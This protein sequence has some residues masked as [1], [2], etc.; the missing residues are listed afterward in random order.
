MLQGTFD[1][2]SFK[3][4]LHLLAS[5]RKTGALRM[6]AGVPST[7]W[8]EDGLCCAAEGGDLI[9]PVT[10]EGEMLARLV[11]IGFA[12]ARNTGGTFRFVAEER[13]TWQSDVRISIDRVLVEVDGLLARWREIESVVPSLECRPTLCDQLGTERLTVDAGR[14]QL[15]VL[16][17]GRRSVRELSHRTGR[18]VFELCRSLIEL[19]DLGA[20]AIAPELELAVVPRPVTEGAVQPEEP[21]GPGV[22]TPHRGP[23]HPELDDLEPGERGALLR[24]FGALKEE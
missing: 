13:S 10:A 20:V 1:T 17:D 7:W 18:S 24:V 6:D 21:Y 11:D 15:I 4:V 23:R 19:V 12:V 14:W 2:L 8:F 3:E 9:D 22:E 16:I 5:S